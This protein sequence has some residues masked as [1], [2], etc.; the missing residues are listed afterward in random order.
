MVQRK[1]LTP[2]D[3]KS[4]DELEKRL[5]VFERR[6]QETAS[7][8]QWTFT[9]KDLTTLLAKDRKQAVAFLS[10]TPI[11]IRHRNSEHEHWAS[12]SNQAYSPMVAKGAP[13]AGSNIRK[14]SGLPTLG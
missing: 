5:L 1:V 11:Q 7:P 8:F 12:S 10:L 13:F 4:L 3:F 9:R 6:Y 14:Q 2:N